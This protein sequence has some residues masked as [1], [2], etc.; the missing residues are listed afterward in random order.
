MGSAY[1]LRGGRSY[2]LK[3]STQITKDLGAVGELHSKEAGGKCEFQAFSK[4]TRDVAGW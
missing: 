4:E 3:K 2:A 1:E